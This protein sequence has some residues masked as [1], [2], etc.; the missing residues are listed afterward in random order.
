MEFKSPVFVCASFSGWP[1]R[2]A[3]F[4]YRN[5]RLHA[6]TRLLDSVELGSTV[7][8]LALIELE[9]IFFNALDWVLRWC[10]GGCFSFWL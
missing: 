10:H 2:E 5:G 9:R 1:E 4:R 7:L 3:E 6:L 8:S